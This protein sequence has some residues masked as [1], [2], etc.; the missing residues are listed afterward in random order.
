MKPN[1]L[2]VCGRNKKRS[3]TAEQIFKND[4]RINIKSAGLSSSSERKIGIKDIKWANYILVMENKY[5]E[6]INDSYKEMTIPKIYVLDIR[7]N[8]EYMDPELC[9][10]LKIKI[11]NVI[12]GLL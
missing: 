3:K 7:D 5:K 12:N 6:R 1:I 8:Y 10:L 4:N 9:E 11:N 2:V